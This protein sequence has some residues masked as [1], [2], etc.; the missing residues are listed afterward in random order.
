MKYEYH[1]ECYCRRC[2]IMRNFYNDMVFF[3]LCLLTITIGVGLCYYL[4]LIS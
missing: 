4:G 3:S 1:D 2:K